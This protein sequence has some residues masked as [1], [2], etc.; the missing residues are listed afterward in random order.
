MPWPTA[1]ARQHSSR[2]YAACAT[3]ALVQGVTRR[4]SG[5][6]AAWP[7]AAQDTPCATRASRSCSKR[8]QPPMST[9]VMHR[10][11]V[12]ACCAVARMCCAASHVVLQGVAVVFLSWIKCTLAAWLLGLTVEQVCQTVIK[13]RTSLRRGSVASELMLQA[14]RREC[15]GEATWFISHTWGNTFVDTLDAILL[16]FEGRHDAASAKV[17]FDVLVDGQH[18][19]AGPSK[20][21]SWYM[22]TFRSSIARI[23]RLLL[24]VDVWNNPTALRRAWCVPARSLRTHACCCAHVMSHCCGVQVCSR[25]ARHCCEESGGI[26]RVR[27]GHDA[28]GTAALLRRHTS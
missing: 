28:A 14:D 5:W 17:W 13:P 26:G 16:F 12:S 3:Q 9:T 27:C 19:I 11:Y 6:G 24:V 23:G 1:A 20:P 4:C 10:W 2:S 7:T 8:L 22:T 15:V 18:A 25:A 21:S